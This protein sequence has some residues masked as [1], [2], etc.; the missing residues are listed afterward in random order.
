MVQLPMSETISLGRLKGHAHNRR[1]R[2]ALAARWRRGYGGGCAD[3]TLR[4]V[5]RLAEIVVEAK[6]RGSRRVTGKSE[7]AGAAF[8]TSTRPAPLCSFPLAGKQP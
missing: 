5:L 1:C 6:Q 8:A 4:G 2:S 7:L 3:F